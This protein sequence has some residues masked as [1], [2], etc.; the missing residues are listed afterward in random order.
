MKTHLK[1]VDIFN[2]CLKTDEKHVIMTL[3]YLYFLS[4]MI[5]EKSRIWLQD[6]IGHKP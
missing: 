1:L 4:F 2:V 6:S 3:I 5:E